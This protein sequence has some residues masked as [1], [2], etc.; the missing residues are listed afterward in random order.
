MLCSPDVVVC[1]EPFKSVDKYLEEDAVD[2]IL[3]MAR[4]GIAVIILTHNAEF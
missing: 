2:M 3:E 4:K 1:V